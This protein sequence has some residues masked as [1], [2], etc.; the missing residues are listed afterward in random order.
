MKN[1]ETEIK[2][3]LVEMDS[4]I[5][6][7]K[8]KKKKKIEKKSCC[9]ILERVAVL[10]MTHKEDG[11]NFM[12]FCDSDTYNGNSNCCAGLQYRYT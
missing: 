6:N 11:R 5:K 7:L 3:K 4:K 2:Q 1:L 8:S 9:W 12:S 10:N